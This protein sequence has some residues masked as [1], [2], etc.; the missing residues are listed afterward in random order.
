MDL[1]FLN[2]YIFLI[3]CLTSMTYLFAFLCAHYTYFRSGNCLCS[4]SNSVNS[5]V[6]EYLGDF[7]LYFWRNL[8]RVGIL[9]QHSLTWRRHN[10]VYELH[11]LFVLKRVTTVC[12]YL[13]LALNFVSQKS[14]WTIFCGI[15]YTIREPIASLFVS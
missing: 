11:T 15:M 7:F 13:Y 9:W 5:K 2:M 1:Y 10:V 4:Y 12:I 3:H 14:K 8:L 6:V